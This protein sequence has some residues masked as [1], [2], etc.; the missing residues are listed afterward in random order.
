M[1]LPDEVQHD[2]KQLG[3]AKLIG[4]RGL[5]VTVAARELCAANGS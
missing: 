4:S 3:S 2:G 1:V 5:D